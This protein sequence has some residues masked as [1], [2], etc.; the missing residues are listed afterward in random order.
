MPLK[1]LFGR[2]K[3]FVMLICLIVK[4]LIHLKTLRA[5]IETVLSQNSASFRISYDSNFKKK[6][7]RLAFLVDS[8]SIPHFNSQ[9]KLISSF[10]AENYQLTWTGFFIELELL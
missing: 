8:P 2:T 3:R 6:I 1:L 10:L 9:K 4:S 7:V 5:D